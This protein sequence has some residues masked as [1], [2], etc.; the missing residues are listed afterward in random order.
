MKY[1]YMKRSNLTPIKVPNDDR[2]DLVIKIKDH[3]WAVKV[4]G[5]WKDPNLYKKKHI[6]FLV[7]MSS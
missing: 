3:T 7:D 6:S 1:L 2:I 5:S 4:E